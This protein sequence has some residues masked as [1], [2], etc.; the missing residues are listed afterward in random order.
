[1]LYEHVLR[2]LLF[3]FS[4]DPEDAH[5]LALRALDALGNSPSLCLMIRDRLVPRDPRLEKKLCG[6]TFPNPIGLAAGFA[7]KPVGLHGLSALG[8]GFIE[9]GTITPR[10]QE[11][12]PRPRIFRLPNDE[13]LVNRMGFNNPGAREAARQLAHQQSLPIPMGINIGKAK[14][15]PLEEADEDYVDC[16][17]QLNLFAD[18]I[19]VNV[20]SPNTPGLRSLQGK[21]QLSRILRALTYARV[22]RTIEYNEPRRPIFVKLTIDLGLEGIDD[23]LDLCTEFDI[24]G[25]IV[26][27]TT[28]TRDHLST[29]TEEKGGLSGPMLLK[30]AC[31]NVAHIRSKLPN[32][33]IIGVGG[34]SSADDVIRMRDA[35]ADLFQ[36]YTSLIYRGPLFPSRLI[37]ALA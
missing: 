32:I 20:S 9:L 16:F 21:E 4:Q 19:V 2:P 11:G 24:D 25:L 5:E 13:A 27:N 26:S 23:V 22:M 37:R 34:I 7:K 14:D 33:A 18:Y 36:V 28:I 10:P 3:R 29:P 12:N 30:R 31:L 8:F 6:I 35:G 1:M 15:T 17:E